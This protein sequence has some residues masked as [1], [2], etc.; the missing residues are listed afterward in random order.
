MEGNQGTTGWDW[1]DEVRATLSLGRAQGPG[2]CSFSEGLDSLC[3]LKVKAAQ[4][5][6]GPATG[7]W[8][9]FHGAYSHLSRSP[10]QSV[11]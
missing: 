6:M 1:R 8:A 9:S 5:N 2:S 4:Q 10:P 7:A 11:A 3:D